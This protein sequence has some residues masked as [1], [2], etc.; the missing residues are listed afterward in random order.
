MCSKHDGNEQIFWGTSV[1]SWRSILNSGWRSDP[2]SSYFS[3]CVLSGFLIV[4]IELDV[5]GVS[6]KVSSCLASFKFS[7][8]ASYIKV[9]KLSGIQIKSTSLWSIWPLRMTRFIK[10]HVLTSNS[11]CN[12]LGTKF[13]LNRKNIFQF[14]SLFPIFGLILTCFWP[15][16]PVGISLSQ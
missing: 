1:L 3:K 12:S 16:W 9:Y 8:S 4:T 10:N 15:V 13:Q 2:Q 11:T 7:V 6:K 14:I 5:L